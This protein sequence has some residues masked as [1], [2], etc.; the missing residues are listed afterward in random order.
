MFGTSLADEASP[1]LC[2]LN[3][4]RRSPKF[5]NELNEAERLN[6]WNDWNG[7]RLH[8]SVCFNATKLLL[9]P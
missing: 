3:I 9:S 2:Y 6:I 7:P 4:S 1:N 5:L 8:E